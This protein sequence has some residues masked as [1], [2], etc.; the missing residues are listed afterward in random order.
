MKWQ[1]LLASDV[2][3]DAEEVTA[4]LDGLGISAK[5]SVEKVG[6]YKY[7]ITFDRVLAHTELRSVGRIDKEE[8]IPEQVPLDPEQV[9]YF[10]RRVAQSLGRSSKAILITDI[11]RGEVVRDP[12]RGDGAYINLEHTFDDGK[13]R[14]GER[15]FCYNWFLEH[16]GLREGDNVVRVAYVTD[17]GKPKQNAGDRVYSPAVLDEV[18]KTSEDS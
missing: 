8:R 15:V 14:E 7:K 4:R 1:V 11:A 3:D 16:H 5:Y 18:G 2:R 9:D 6:E 10:T 12:G 17:A 13:T